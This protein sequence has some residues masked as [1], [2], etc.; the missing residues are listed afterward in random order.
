[1]GLTT[2]PYYRRSH[3]KK[4]PDDQS[5]GR[6]WVEEKGNAELQG[7]GQETNLAKHM[8][9]QGIQN[10]VPHTVVHSPKPALFT[11]TRL[12]QQG[13]GQCRQFTEGTTSKCPVKLIFF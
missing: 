9:N 2:I 3:V 6:K 4:K 7:H 8:E 13:K 12:K 5:K 11:V 1:M 10:P